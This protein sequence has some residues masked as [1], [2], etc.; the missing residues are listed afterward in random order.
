MAAKDHRAVAETGRAG[1]GGTAPS[2]VR[3]NRG[4]GHDAR[5]SGPAAAKASK[6][7]WPSCRCSHAQRV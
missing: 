4:T 6:T 2:D 5:V 3:R 7:R 1:V